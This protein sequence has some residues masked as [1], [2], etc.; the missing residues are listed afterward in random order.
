MEYEKLGWDFLQRVDVIFYL[1]T[2]HN[3]QYSISVDSKKNIY[4][5]FYNLLTETIK[6]SK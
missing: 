4:E 5:S 1:K 2:C 3:L 6:S